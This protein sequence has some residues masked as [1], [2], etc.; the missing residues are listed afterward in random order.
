MELESKVSG[1]R[2]T[3]CVGA[4]RHFFGRCSRL[5]VL[6][7]DLSILGGRCKLRA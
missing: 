2:L 6:S 5:D 7:N 3:A 1:K 4:L